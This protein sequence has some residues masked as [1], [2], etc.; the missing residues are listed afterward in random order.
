MISINKININAY[1]F[2]ENNNNIFIIIIFNNHKY[3][4]GL[5]VA[6]TSGTAFYFEPDIAESKKIKK[7]YSKYLLQKD[8]SYLYDLQFS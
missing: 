1:K 8:Y 7:R 5:Y 2:V 3:T 4:G 6:S